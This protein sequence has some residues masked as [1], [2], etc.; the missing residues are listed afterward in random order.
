MLRSNAPDL[1]LLFALPVA[2]LALMLASAQRFWV[3]AAFL[4]WFG[5]AALPGIA[6]MAGLTHGRRS[7]VMLALGALI[8][9]AS[10]A[11]NLALIDRC[12]AAC[13]LE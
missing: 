12:G 10:C 4:W 13:R 2:A 11:A 9:A 5:L 1:A 7:L 3:P 8:L 6:L